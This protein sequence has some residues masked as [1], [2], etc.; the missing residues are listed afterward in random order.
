MMSDTVWGNLTQEELNRQYDQSTLVPNVDALMEVNAKDSAKIR[1]E[2]DC[3]QNVSYGPTVME[4]LDIFRV[5]TKG[6]PVAIYHHGGAWTRYDKDR[7]SYIAPSLVA[8][9]VNVLVLE[10]ALAPKVSLEE[11]I[12]QNRAAICWAWHNAD[13]Y[14]WDRNRIHSLGHSSGGH[15]CGMMLVTNWEDDYALP[16]NI[17]K[18]AV[19]CSG[20]YELET[21]PVSVIAIPIS[22]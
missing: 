1:S 5:A 15:I 3:I 11:I 13:E 19:S 12:R 17:I 2:L 6:A 7:C 18:S 20:I 16:M 10:F 22:I 4:R 9:G 8:A 14:G 21:G